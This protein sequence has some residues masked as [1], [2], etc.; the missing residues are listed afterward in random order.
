MK[1]LLNFI[2]RYAAWFI[3]AIYVAVSVMLIVANNNYQ[4]SVYLTSANVVTGSVYDVSSQVTGYFHLRSINRD[5]QANNAK[6]QN[7]VLNLRQELAEYKA[8]YA[9][10]DTLNPVMYNSRFDYVTA[11]VIN[12]NTRHP[13]NYFTINKGALDGVKTGMGI[14]DHNGVTGIVDVVGPHMSRAISLLNES[15][16]FSVK[17][18]GTEYVGSL[19]WKGQDP[20]VAYVEEIPRH[21]VYHLGDTIVT[22][23]YSTTYPEGIPVGTVISRV[24][25][26][27]DS[28]FTFK[29]RLASDFRAL[30]TVRI[31]KDYYKAEIDSLAESTREPDVKPASK[32]K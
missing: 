21:A 4:H 17:V 3:F 19:S 26:S 14:V 13:K 20:T 2:L 1:N 25:G 15:Q 31:I 27:D 11:A 24:R 6:L 9:D 32:K 10:A 29:I 28:Y 23:G 5:L 12:N 8:L 7:E 18:K 30:S 16:H 22:S